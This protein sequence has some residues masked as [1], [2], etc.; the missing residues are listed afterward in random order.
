MVADE[1]GPLV[2]VFDEA[3][4]SGVGEEVDG[5]GEE[6]GVIGD[7][8]GVIAV[9]EDGA[10]ALTEGVDESGEARLEVAH[11][12]GE[13]EVWCAEDEVEVVGEEDKGEDLDLIF[14]LRVG[15]EFEDEL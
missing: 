5:E 11:K 15:E 1:G 9:G 13:V 7:E 10:A 14:A 4:A 8:V 12:L 3:R 6:G 2:G